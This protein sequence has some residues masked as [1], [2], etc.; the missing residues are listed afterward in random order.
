MKVQIIIEAEVHKELEYM[1]KD[2][3]P[4]TFKETVQ[5]CLQDDFM[6]LNINEANVIYEIIK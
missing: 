4:D 1:I 6:E 3:T 5:I 2:Y